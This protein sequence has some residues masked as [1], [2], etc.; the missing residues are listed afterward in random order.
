MITVNETHDPTL[1]S[2]VES[3]NSEDCDFSIQNLPFAVFRRKSSNE[4]FRGGVAIGDHE[5]IVQGVWVA[6]RVVER[7]VMTVVA[8]AGNGTRAPGRREGGGLVS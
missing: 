4:A 8:G 3:A 1:V 7:G 5:R 2:W 6:G